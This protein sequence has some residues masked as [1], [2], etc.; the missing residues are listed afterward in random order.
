MFQGSQG[1]DVLI[2]NVSFYKS[3]RFPLFESSGVGAVVLGF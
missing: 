2:L 3:T 1:S